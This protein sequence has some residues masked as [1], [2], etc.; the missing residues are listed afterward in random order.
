M[1]VTFW[2]ISL[3]KTQHTKKDTLRPLTL[4][5]SRPIERCLEPKHYG[6]MAAWQGWVP[7]DGCLSFPNRQLSDSFHGAPQ[8]VLPKWALAVAALTQLRDT[9]LCILSYI[10]SLNSTRLH[11]ALWNHIL[12]DLKSAF[13]SGSPF[14]RTKANSWKI[15]FTNYLH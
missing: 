8:K 1:V 13:G 2:T 4:E 14:E 6:T 12:N 5:C 3:P 15:S 10:S 7:G 9:R 11:Q